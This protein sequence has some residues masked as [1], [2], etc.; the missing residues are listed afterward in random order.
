MA[1][2]R[3][4]ILGLGLLAAAAAAAAGPCEEERAATGL[5]LGNHAGTL[6]VE[7]VDAGSPAA[8]AGVQPGDVVAQVNW[9][10]SDLI[11]QCAKRSSVSLPAM[12]GGS[13]GGSRG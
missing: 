12:S 5:A 1:G 9:K 8:R 4:V 2:A 3:G 6:A 10:C 13:E 7:A 11:R